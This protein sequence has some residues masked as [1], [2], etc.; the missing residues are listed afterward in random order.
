MSKREQTVIAVP[1]FD[2]LQLLLK[3][4]LHAPRKTMKVQFQQTGINFESCFMFAVAL[5]VATHRF[6]GRNEGA[7]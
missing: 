2:F 5:A 4:K 1:L 6:M 3:L 7:K